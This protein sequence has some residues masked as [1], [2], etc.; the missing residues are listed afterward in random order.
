MSG[1]CFLI[2]LIVYTPAMGSSLLLHISVIRAIFFSSLFWILKAKIYSHFSKCL[3][4][5]NWINSVDRLGTSLNSYSYVTLLYFGLSSTQNSKLFLLL[6]GI[7]ISRSVIILKS[8][9]AYISMTS[10]YVNGRN[11]TSS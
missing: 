6:R 1:I 10:K 8:A 3:F 2:I 5:I 4:E 9:F 7:G 11:S